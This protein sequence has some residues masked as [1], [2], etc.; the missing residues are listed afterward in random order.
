MQ[1]L[2]N[3]SQPMLANV[4]GFSRRAFLFEQ[5]CYQQMICLNGFHFLGDLYKTYRLSDDSLKK[6][7]TGIVNDAEWGYT[8]EIR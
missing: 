3:K 8:G 4:S 2:F 6:L 7:K 1:K 5:P